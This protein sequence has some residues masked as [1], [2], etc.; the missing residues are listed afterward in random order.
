MNP[1][2]WSKCELELETEMWPDQEL[3]VEHC[4][5]GW[6]RLS[7]GASHLQSTFAFCLMNNAF[8]IKPVS[9]VCEYSQ[10]MT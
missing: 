1:R 6:L 5:I 10:V 9:A 7:F 3:G 8:T 2:N 4:F